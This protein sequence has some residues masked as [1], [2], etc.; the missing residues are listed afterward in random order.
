M[1]PDPGATHYELLGV[2]L[3]A[4]CHQISQMRRTLSRRFHTDNG[5]E[6]NGELMARINHAID[7]LGDRQKRRKYD[8]S[9]WENEHHRAR[10]AAERLRHE[11][12]EE[13]RADEIDAFAA[14]LSGDRSGHGA[15]V[16]PPSAARARVA[17]STGPAA[18]MAAADSV[19][20]PLH[21]RLTVPF[22]RRARG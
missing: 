12:A 17:V 7:V 2:P 22:G 18:A 4:T 9:L 15:S 13:I 6:A 10:A 14:A 21:R 3:D 16:P 11:R 5:V 20:A 1:N 19:A 8:D